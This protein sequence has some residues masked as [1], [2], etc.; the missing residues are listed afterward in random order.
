MFGRGSGMRWTWL[1]VI[2]P[3]AVLAGCASAPNNGI[4]P[5]EG[6]VHAPGSVATSEAVLELEAPETVPA[7]GLLQVEAT[8]RNPG[9]GILE[10]RNAS[11]CPD[12]ALEVRF[13]DDALPMRRL[14]GVDPCP[15]NGRILEVPSGN[16][17]RGPYVLDLARLQ[18]EG[19]HLDP[20]ARLRLEAE[21]EGN[22]TANLSARAEVT[23]SSPLDLARVEVEP[24]NDSWPRGAA[25]AVD[26]V[27]RPTH[28]PFL[29]EGGTGCLGFEAWATPAGAGSPRVSI[30][31]GPNATCQD[32]TRVVAMQPS[33]ESSATV[34][35][36]GWLP[37]DVPDRLRGPGEWD[38][39]AR[40]VAPSASWNT[41][42]STEVAVEPG[43]RVEVQTHGPYRVSQVRPLDVVLEN[44]TDRTLMLGP[45]DRCAAADVTLRP[46]AEGPRYV[47][48]LLPPRDDG[49]LP[50]SVPSGENARISYRW[51]GGRTTAG[52]TDRWRG[53]AEA[54]AYEATASLHASNVS[55]RWTDEARVELEPPDRE[56]ESLPRLQLEPHTD[57]LEAGL[58]VR[59]DAILDLPEDRT[60][61][62]LNQNSCT[63]PDFR[64]RHEDANGSTTWPF[65]QVCAT[66]ITPVHLGPG[67]THETVTIW[68]G[69][70]A[71]DQAPY[72][73]PPGDVTFTVGY[74]STGQ[75]RGGPW[76]ASASTT[77]TLVPRS[78][79]PRIQ[80]DP[81]RETVPE[82]GNTTVYLNF[83]N[84]RDEPFRFQQL[85]IAPCLLAEVFVVD[86]GGRKQIEY[87]VTEEPCEAE[88]TIPAGAERSWTIDLDGEFLQDGERTIWARFGGW[89]H[90]WYHHGNATVTVE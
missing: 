74:S 47:P 84:T 17:T 36:T 5:G 73:V 16:V 56:N 55:S 34:R 25:Q 12:V 26:L 11:R 64:L 19:A 28:R 27:F 89:G 90:P 87:V 71:P 62:Y 82:D 24:R 20:G 85:E 65:R 43:V 77:V 48:L 3:A 67:G 63:G 7:N 80:V 69:A 37:E 14:V 42:G 4:D 76:N 68:S 83:T 53:Y 35:W 29:A 6:P 57:S 81:V 88:T 78:D 2:I 79:G 59:L 33:E 44:P 18:A 50:D 10:I 75:D 1:L 13:G 61:G 51:D 30:E 45:L 72:E 22:T 31:T 39:H 60:F 40:L 52:G 8:L 54:G 38:L 49:C 32:R 58:P 66:A 70:M 9:P 86:D 41:T 15:G 21:L 23:L 46:L